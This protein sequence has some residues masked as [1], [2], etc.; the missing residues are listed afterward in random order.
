[1]AVQVSLVPGANELCGQIGP[2]VNATA[3]DTWVSFTTTL[4][5]A[6]LPVLVTKKL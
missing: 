3:G 4:V 2:D 5:N 1:M 6:V